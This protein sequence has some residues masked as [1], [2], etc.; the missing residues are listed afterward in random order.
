MVFLVSQTKLIL[1]LL[2]QILSNNEGK[3][4]GGGVRRSEGHTIFYL[5]DVT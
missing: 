3:K 1:S 2:G 4:K 5:E